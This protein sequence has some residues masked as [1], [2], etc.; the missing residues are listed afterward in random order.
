MLEMLPLSPEFFFLSVPVA[1]SGIRQK[2]ATACGFEPAAD[3][4]HFK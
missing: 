3:L 1:S 4:M 2:S